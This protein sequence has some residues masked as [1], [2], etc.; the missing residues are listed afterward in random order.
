MVSNYARGYQGYESDFSD[1]DGE[2]ETNAKKRRSKEDEALVK[3]PFQ[4][5]KH[6]KVAHKRVA[7]EEWDREEARNR[8]F[9]LISMDAFARHQKFVNDYILYY[10]GKL[11]DFKL[12]KGE[13][14]TDLD[15]I[16]ENHRFLWQEEDEE[17]MTWEKR[18]ARKYYD[19]LFKEY[20]IADLSRYKENKF[21]FRWRV[22]KEV[23]SGKGQF[24]CGNKRCDEK[25]GLKSWEVNFGYIEHDEK[26]NAL[27][28]LRLCPECSYKLNFHHKRKEVQPKAKI[29]KA[30]EDTGEPSGKKSK[31]SR[32]RKK[33]KG[34]DKS[35][36]RH[37]DSSEEDTD[38]DQEDGNDESA[39]SDFWKGPQ[40]EPDEKTREEEFDEYFQD[41]FL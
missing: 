35:T 31:H 26:K 29:G 32:S 34:K 37:G 16:R 13:R 6:G 3:K 33:R 28:K 14:K 10:G 15:V 18:L 7:A 30:S 8:R 36:H 22:E 4:K 27:V 20:C 2:P 40:Q 23:I 38:N 19:K 41:M 24:S 5:E 1:E 12:S 11:E 9:H 21:G 17:E 25:E 39:N